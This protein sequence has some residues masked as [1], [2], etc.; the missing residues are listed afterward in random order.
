L[1]VGL[2]VLVLRRGYF[3]RSDEKGGAML[4]RLTGLCCG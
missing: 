2:E 4:V 1:S 3:H